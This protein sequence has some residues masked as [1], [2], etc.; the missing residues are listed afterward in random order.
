MNS[1]TFKQPISE[2]LFF[3]KYGLHGESKAEEVFMG[4]AEDISSVENDKKW[5][6]IFTRSNIY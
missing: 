2:S 3:R 1:F 4:V 6:N 5:K